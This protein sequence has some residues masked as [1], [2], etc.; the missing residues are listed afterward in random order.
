MYTAE[1]CLNKFTLYVSN[2]VAPYFKRDI[3][4]CLIEHTYKYIFNNYA[5]LPF[6]FFLFFLS[7]VSAFS[8]AEINLNESVL[9]YIIHHMHVS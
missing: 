7:I 3:R 4:Y 9:P 5:V 1:P 2:V 8:P 6:S